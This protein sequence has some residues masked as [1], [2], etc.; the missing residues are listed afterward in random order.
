MRIFIQLGELIEGEIEKHDASESEI[1][2]PI[3]FH[4]KPIE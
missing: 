3:E 4:F 1:T 2:I